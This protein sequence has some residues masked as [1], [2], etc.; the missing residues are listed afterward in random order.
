M[1]LSHRCLFLC[2]FGVWLRGPYFVHMCD[3]GGLNWGCFPPERKI[4]I[5]FFWKA[6]MEECHTTGTTF[7]PSFPI[8]S[9][10]QSLFLTT[11]FLN[12]WT[13]LAVC[14]RAIW[15]SCLFIAHLHYFNFGVCLGRPEDFLYFPKAQRYIKNK[16]T[17]DLISDHYTARGRGLPIHFSHSQDDL[18]SSN[19]IM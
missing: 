13:D 2:M 7:I 15:V 10:S 6:A 17:H 12:L 9:Q 16:F 11:Q 19:L 3:S 5:C 4:C 1:I 8:L 18:L 14:S